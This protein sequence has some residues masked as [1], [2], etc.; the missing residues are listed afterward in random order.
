MKFLYTLDS[1]C[2]RFEKFVISWSIIIMALVAILNVLGR[3]LF[4]HSFTWAEE[5]T[6]FTIVWITFVGSSY[7]ARI[8]AHIRISTLSDVLGQRGRKILMIVVSAGT[9][10]LMFYLGWYAYLYVAKLAEIKKQTLG[11]QIPL[12]LIMLWVPVGFVMTGIQYVLALIKNLTSKEVYLSAMVLE[13]HAE[14]NQSFDF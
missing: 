6:Q 1:F 5:V 10:A 4:H 12:Y 2:E 3:N 9:A 14:D 7:A 11:L 13:G 8:G